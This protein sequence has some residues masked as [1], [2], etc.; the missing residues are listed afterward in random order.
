MEHPRS[1]SNFLLMELR[2]LSQANVPFVMLEDM[3]L[4]SMTVSN[5]QQLALDNGFEQI[6]CEK[7]GLYKDPMRAS[8]PIK[9]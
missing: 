5:A 3:A 1:F 8:W 6:P 7:M 2:T 9:E 4:R